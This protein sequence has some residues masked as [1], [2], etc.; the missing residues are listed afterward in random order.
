MDFRQAKGIIRAALRE[1]SDGKLIEVLEAAR[2]RQMPWISCH[3]C[4]AGRL[5]GGGPDVAFSDESDAYATLGG[6]ITNNYTTFLKA[7]QVTDLTRQR[8]LVPMVLAEMKRRMAQESA[9]TARAIVNE[10]VEVRTIAELIR[11]R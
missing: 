5:R 3:M 1:A 8:V 10:A 7:L 4:L 6:P 11:C 9:A 2:A